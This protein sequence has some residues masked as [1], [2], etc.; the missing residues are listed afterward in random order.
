MTALEHFVS[1]A[2]TRALG[3]TLLHSLWQGALVAAVLAGALGLVVVLA[4]FTFGLYF[5]AGAGEE[6][7]PRSV[8]GRA[9]EAFSTAPAAALVALASD[10]RFPAGAVSGQSA[11]ANEP[12]RS[13]A[14][15]ASLARLT[16]PAG[17][18]DARHSA[19]QAI[20]QSLSGYFDQHLPLLVL[21]WV[22]GLLGMSLRMLA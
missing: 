20:Q 21:A 7:L 2:L 9:V 17:Q 10:N 12:A 5:T 19:V 8:A 15:A 4:G 1:P 14:D 22:L 18:P 13:T 3:W 11:A 16:P 6:A